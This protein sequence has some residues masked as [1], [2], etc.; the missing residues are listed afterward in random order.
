MELRQKVVVFE[1]GRKLAKSVKWTY[2]VNLLEVTNS[3][4]CIYAGLLF[5]QQLSLNTTVDE[6]VCNGKRAHITMYAVEVTYCTKRFSKCL[7]LKY[8]LRCYTVSK[9]GVLNL[10]SV[11]NDFKLTLVSVLCVQIK[12]R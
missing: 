3:Y 7:R 2:R 11:W 10:T 12:K 4:H 9:F 5:T 1:M 6:F 8:V